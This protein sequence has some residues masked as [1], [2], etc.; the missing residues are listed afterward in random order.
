MTDRELLRLA[1]KAAGWKAI[2][3]LCDSGNGMA[4][5]YDADGRHEYWNP[6]EPGADAFRLAVELNQ[7]ICIFPHEVEVFTEEGECVS[8]ALDDGDDKELVVCRAIV[9]AAAE[10]GRSME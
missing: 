8:I 6:L 2:D 4:N 9:Q 3:F 10:I 5:V 7:T 1:A